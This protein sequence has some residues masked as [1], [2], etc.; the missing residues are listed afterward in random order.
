MNCIER[1]PLPSMSATKALPYPSISLRSARLPAPKASV[2]QRV[3]TALTELSISTKLIL[4]TK[5]NVDKLDALQTALG[6]LV[7][8]KK[9]VDRAEGELRMMR[10]RKELLNGIVAE[11]E[12][13]KKAVVAAAT[14]QDDSAR[15][16]FLT[17]FSPVYRADFPSS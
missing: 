4:P 16:R 17:S 8:M 5:E 9:M 14:A 1:H 7:E 11:E 2:A 13:A 15:V 10:K 12:E 6:G 3:A